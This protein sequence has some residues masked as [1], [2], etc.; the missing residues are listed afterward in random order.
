MRLIVGCILLWA[1]QPGSCL[2]VAAGQAPRP[3][4]LNSMRLERSVTGLGY[5]EGELLVKF[6]EGPRSRQAAT[7]NSVLGCSAI[8]SFPRVGWQHVRLPAGMSVSEAVVLYVNSPGVLAAE[9][10]GYLSLAD[11]GVVSDDPRLAEQWGLAKI[12]ASMAWALNTGSP[13]VVVAIIDSGVNYNH[14]DLA[15]NMWQ[16]P[17][18]LGVDGEGNQKHNN[19]IDDDGN[20][21]VDDLYGIE[22]GSGDSDPLDENDHGTHIAGIIG[23]VGNNGLGV[24]GINWDTRLMALKSWGGGGA[25]TFES[26]L[27]ECYEYILMM[28]ERR[29]DVRVTNNSYGSDS[30]QQALRDAIEAAGA[31]GILNVFVA[32]N[33]ARDIDVAPLFPASFDSPSIIAV[34][35]TQLDASGADVH[36]PT[37]NW[38]AESVDL[39][40]P[41]TSILSTSRG[42]GYALWS[43][44]SFAAPHVVGAAAL[45]WS[46]DPDASAAMVKSAIVDSVDLLPSLD[47]KVLSGGRLNVARAALR[48]IAPDAPSV[49]LSAQPSGA[50]TS[51]DSEVHLSFSKPMNRT[52]VE[53]GFSVS[54]SIPVF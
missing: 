33:H 11:G 28:K 17:G 15:D 7:I 51:V 46:I 47:G 40:A 43:G 9:P 34:T 3:E 30:P 2:Q 19:G 36:D 22:A 48:L 8:K 50:G 54:Q 53:E 32:H 6:G 26:R 13:D 52:S 45:L 20:G 31:M 24:A 25:G 38:G 21:Y 4:A 23:A 16:N 37:T 14:E 1:I 5:A 49:V 10:N 12:D 27:I 39:A 29:V 35:S 42:G 41:G 44:T 18:E